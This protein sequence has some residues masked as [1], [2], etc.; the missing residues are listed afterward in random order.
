MNINLQREIFR[1]EE[2]DKWFSRNL[3]NLEKDFKPE[4]DRIISV[5]KRIKSTTANKDQKLLEIGCGGV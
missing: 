1:N 5:L 4:E 3:S 2:G